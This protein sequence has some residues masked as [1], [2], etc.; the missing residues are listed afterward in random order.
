[1]PELPDVEVFRQRLAEHSLNSEIEKVEVKDE[2]ILKDI[3]PQTFASRLSGR[4][5]VATS[6]HGKYCFVEVDGRTGWLVLHFGM[7]GTVTTVQSREDMPRHGAARF[8]MAS[9]SD[10]VYI[11][12]RKLGFIRLIQDREAF[13]QEQKL[14]PDPMDPSFDRET[15]LDLLAKR[16][17]RLKTAF[18]NQSLLA[19]IG[20]VYADEILFQAG[21]HPGVKISDLSREQFSHVY[22]TMDRVLK[23]AI[24][25][26][27]DPERL[28]GDFLTPRR[29]EN[30]PCPVCGGQIKRISFSGRS[31][32]FCPSCQA[33]A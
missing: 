30:E 19:G 1:M 5:F 6:R 18:M 28:P 8:V 27:A 11:S 22:E 24:E 17:G 33:K 12:K 7:T 31:A 13:I 10:L 20:N 3:T 21:L 32:Y 23:S 29:S 16:K 14:G 2:R 9:G 25:H 26:G 15:F 4:K